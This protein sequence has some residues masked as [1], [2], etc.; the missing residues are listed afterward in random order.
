M[1]SV[2]KDTLENFMSNMDTRLD[3]IF[4]DFPYETTNCSWD[5]PIDLP[6]FWEHAWR[7]LK[8]NGVVIATAQPPYNI[9]LANSQFENY[10]Y[11]WIFHKT[12]AS[13][14]LNAKK[15]PM[16]SHENV[17]IFY[18]SLPTYNPQ[19]TTGHRKVTVSAKNRIDGIVRENNKDNLY[20]KQ[21]TKNAS[22][23]SST[24]R[25]PRS[26]LKFSKDMQTSSI[27]PTQKP[28][29][30]VG[31]LIST[32][33]NVGDTVADF[34]AG[35][36]TTGVVCSKLR[37]NCILVDRDQKWVDEIHDRMSKISIPFNGKYLTKRDTP[38]PKYLPII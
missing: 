3:A 35:S 13:G 33:T 26:V 9:K 37:R 25:Y 2:H 32:Y 15:M 22:G 16:K 21:S 14:H 31:Y 1:V 4:A 36:G 8:P 10:K 23:Y 7:L 11:D 20:N 24:E 18:K 5:T 38:Q 29:G 34:T 12:H 28:E 19:K 17:L 30:L 27:H 6:L